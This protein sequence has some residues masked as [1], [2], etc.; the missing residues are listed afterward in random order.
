[1]IKS[2]KLQVLTNLI[3]E[4]NQFQILHEL[5]AY[6]S[7]NDDPLTPHVIQSIGRCVSESNNLKDTCINGLM[8]LLS[9]KN[10][11]VIAETVIVMKK[12]LQYYKTNPEDIITKMAQLFSKIH[13]PKARVAILGLLGQYCEL[14]PDIVPDILRMTAKSFQTEVITYIYFMHVL[15]F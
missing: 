10:E 13:N 2:L 14:I 6:L 11:H 12:L 1:M 15:D 5:Q 3:T 8:K 9:H 7:I 4:S